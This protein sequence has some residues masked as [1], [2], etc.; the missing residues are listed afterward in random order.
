MSTGLLDP[1]EALGRAVSAND[2]AA[3]RRVL[4]GHPELKARLD[5]AVPHDSFGA[6]ALLTAVHHKNRELIEVLLQAG[7]DINVGSH[8]WAGSFGVLDDDSGLEDFLIEH[9]AL[10]TAHAAARLGRLDRLRELVS[11]DPAVVHQR[12]GDGQTPLHFAASVEVAAFLLEHGAEI[13]ALDIDHESTPAQW[14]LEN[15][16]DVARYLV[17]QGCRTDILMAAAL[18]DLPLVQ[19][20]LEADPANLRLSVS[21]EWFP[22]RDPRSAGTI[23]SWTLDRDKTAHFVARMFGH[24]EIYRYLM[25]RSPAELQ[26]TIACEVGDEA[27]VRELLARRPDLVGALSEAEQRKLPLAGKDNNVKAVRLMLAAGWPVDTRGSQH[28]ETALHWAAFHGS[29]DL[30]REIL[31]YSPDLELTSLEYPGTALHWGIY[32]SK[33]GWHPER[34][35]YAMT[36]QLLLEAGAKPPPPS[37]SLEAS[38]AVLAVLRRKT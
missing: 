2:T 24:Q 15:R 31:P 17:S 30:V 1:L 38:E 21:D 23:Y 37:G 25:A 16:H 32:G 12:G 18:G 33:H 13:D 11:N 10:V 28:G 9:G 14:M 26:L 36:V 6:T 4:A 27:L 29:P 22:R 5:E 34:G 7:A 35:D 20:H 19:R 8:W 3:A